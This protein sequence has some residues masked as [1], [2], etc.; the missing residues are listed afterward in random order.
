MTIL[1]FAVGLAAAFITIVGYVTWR[2]RGRRASF[3]DPSISRDAL[4]DADRQAIRGRF[5]G[6]LG[7]LGMPANGSAA[8]RSRGNGG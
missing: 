5:A 3:E 8:F 1:I 7:D 4:V 6:Y 2:D